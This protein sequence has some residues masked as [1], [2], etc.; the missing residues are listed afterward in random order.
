MLSLLDRSKLQSDHIKQLLA[1]YCITK[2]QINNYFRFFRF[3]EIKRSSK[4][5]KTSF[6]M[7][8]FVCVMSFCIVMDG[9]VAPFPVDDPR[10][11]LNPLILPWW[12][13]APIGIRRI[14]HLIGTGQPL[15]EGPGVKE[16]MIAAA[17]PR[18]NRRLSRRLNRP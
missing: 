3:F 8:L 16:A 6:C 4:T 1:F 18:R 10:S 17:T 11:V 2:N 15:P 7:F 14:A 9:V 13:S 5:M 12:G